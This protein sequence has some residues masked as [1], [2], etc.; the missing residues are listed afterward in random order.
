M[1]PCRAKNAAA[2]KRT[3]LMPEEATRKMGEATLAFVTNQYALVQVAPCMLVQ[4]L[5]ACRFLMVDQA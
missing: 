1:L 4:L 5:W 2:G 3:K